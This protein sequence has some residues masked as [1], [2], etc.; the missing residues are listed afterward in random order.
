MEPIKKDGTVIM[1]LHTGSE[2]HG[3]V[4]ALSPHTALTLLHALGAAMVEISDS[5]DRL[6]DGLTLNIELEPYDGE[7]IVRVRAENP[8]DGL[9]PPG[10]KNEAEVA[11]AD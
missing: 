3:I 1:A 9:V 11:E 7:P 10:L 5:S 6:R 2:G 4:V 8:K